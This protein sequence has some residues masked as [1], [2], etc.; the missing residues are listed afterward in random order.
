MFWRAERGRGCFGDGLDEKSTPG[1]CL[2]VIRHRSFVLEFCLV[3]LHLQVLFRLI[4]VRYNRERD[5]KRYRDREGLRAC[6]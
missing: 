5:R 2:R 6:I 3:S 1:L 4:Q